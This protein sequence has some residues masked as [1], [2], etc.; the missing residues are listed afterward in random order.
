MTDNNDDV[1]TGT[2]TEPIAALTAERDELKDRLLRMTAEFDN[3]RKRVDRERRELSEAAAAD[4]IRDLLPIIDDLER[5]MAA[6]GAEDSALVRGVEL[7]H[8]QLLE[9]LRR[10]GVEPVETVGQMFDPQVHEAVGSVP[11]DGRADGEIVAEF[12]KGYRAG[13]RLLR[14]AMVQVAKA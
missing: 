13:G 6:A 7:T 4:L 3:Y 5:A 11:A 10:R 9:Q 14:A 1:F 12:R 2:A 8:R